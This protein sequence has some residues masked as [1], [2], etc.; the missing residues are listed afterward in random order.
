MGWTLE[1]VYG[2][3]ELP[4]QIPVRADP[5]DPVDYGM[6]G[7][8]FGWAFWLHD[9][10]TRSC[11]LTT[12]VD[13]DT[14]CNASDNCPNVYNPTQVNTD[15]PADLQG[16]ACDD[17]D[18]ADGV[19]DTAD[20]C[21]TRKNASPAGGLLSWQRATG[22]QLDDDVDGFGNE[23]DADYNQASAA[24]DST[25]LALFKVAF[26]KKRSSSICNP[27][28]SSPCDIYDHN[29]AVAVIESGDLTAFKVL[30]GQTKKT[31]GD[32]M[33]K[34]GSCPLSCTAGSNDACP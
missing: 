8:Q 30:F 6:G 12:D 23:C 10:A 29:N 21:I 5:N 33:E 15:Y 26:G 14:I 34:C 27:G 17:D 7:E 22:G 18:D 28:G 31:D 13:A 24:V 20:N 25:D 19:P 16:D 2:S 9:P 3:I 11:S 1:Q 4:M 32:R